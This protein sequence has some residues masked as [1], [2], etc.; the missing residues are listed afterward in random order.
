MT[1]ILSGVLWADVFFVIGMVCLLVGVTY[2]FV[3]I[4]EDISYFLEKWRRQ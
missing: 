4:A 1:Y 2:V 3:Q